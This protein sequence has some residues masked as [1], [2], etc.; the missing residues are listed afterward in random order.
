MIL[1][2]NCYQKYKAKDRRELSGTDIIL[3]ILM[4]IVTI[5]TYIGYIPQIV[6]LIKT[7]KSDDLSLSSWVLWITT[8][9]ADMVYSLILGR[10]E[11][12]VATI[13]ELLLEIVVLALTIKYKER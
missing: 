7:K 10:W 9:V 5:C 2:L 12:I 3:Y 11:M 1:S 13:S 6:K 4:W 8:S